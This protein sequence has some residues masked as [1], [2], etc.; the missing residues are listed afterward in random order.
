MD[1]QV[2]RG[3]ML[4]VEVAQEVLV[5]VR[6]RPCPSRRAA[7]RGRCSSSCSESAPPL[8]SQCDA[9]SLSV[10]AMAASIICSWLPIRLTTRVGR[11]RRSGQQ[12][13]DD[14]RAVRC[15]GRHSRPGGPASCRSVGRSAMSSAISLMQ[16]HAGGRCSRGCRRSHR[17]AGRAARWRVR[18]EIHHDRPCRAPRP[19]AK[20]LIHRS[21]NRHRKPGVHTSVP[22]ASA[23]G[24]IPWLIRPRPCHRHAHSM[25]DNRG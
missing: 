17:S 15:R 20:G 24:L 14:L 6:D 23:P 1:E 12:P 25:H 7:Q 16:R 19:S 2:G 11:N 5:A 3:E 18:G 10:P 9:A 21:G 22:S 4:Q 13:V 8:V